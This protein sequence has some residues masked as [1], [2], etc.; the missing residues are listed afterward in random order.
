MKFKTHTLLVQ[1]IHEKNIN[2]EDNRKKLYKII[3]I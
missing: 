1:K 3:Y 2:K